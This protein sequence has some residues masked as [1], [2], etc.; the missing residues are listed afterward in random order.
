MYVAL[1][2]IAAALHAVSWLCHHLLVTPRP[3]FPLSEPRFPYLFSGDDAPCVQTWGLRCVSQLQLLKHGPGA[4]YRN[5]PAQ[6]PGLPDQ[7]LWKW[8]LGICIH[9]ACR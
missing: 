3:S 2:K 7:N 5:H 1:T 6:S 4:V 9:T 8:S